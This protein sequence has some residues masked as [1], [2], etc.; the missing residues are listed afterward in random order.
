MAENL[1]IE[2]VDNKK[3]LRL[4][5]K[6]P[7]EIYQNDPNW[8]PPLYLEMKEKLNRRKNPFFEHAEMELY[9]AK[10][11]GRVVGRVA[12]LIDYHHN[13][14]QKEKIVFFGLYESINDEKVA[15]ALLEAVAQWGKNKGMEVLRGPVNLSMNDECAFLLEGFDQPPVIMM[16]YNPPYYLELMEKAGLR[17]AKDLYAFVMSRD[18][19]IKE[20]VEAVVEKVRRATSFGLRIVNMKKIEEEARKIAYIYNQAWAKNWGFV[21]WTE[22]EMKFMA[23]RLKNFAD[24]ELVIFA[25][26]EGREVGFA[27]GL[28]NYNEIT[29]DLNGR[30]F[31]FG[32]FKLLFGRRKIKG[33][34][35]IVFGVLPE[36][37]HTGLS[38]L[39]YAELERR[40]KNAGYEWAETSW[41]LEDN[42][43]INRFTA[44]IGGKI[45]KKYRIYEKKLI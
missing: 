13:E 33:M 14:Y 12:G 4:F 36:V 9:L 23:K 19:E 17:K 32:I 6:F 27:F 18:H 34:R 3:N 15:Q 11:S 39:L 35:A 45:Y 37:Q 43:A 24:P 20:K 40:A 8:V 5:I 29:K 28:P 7:W 41:Q 22:N 2:P 25:L 26:H 21:P 1:I 38:Y 10:K 42:E 31:P 16:P 44:S 30:L